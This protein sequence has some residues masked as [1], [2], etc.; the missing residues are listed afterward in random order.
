MNTYIGPLPST[1][2]GLL[3]LGPKSKG[4]AG[5]TIKPTMLVATTFYNSHASLTYVDSVLARNAREFTNE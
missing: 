3:N 1:I 5:F 4:F 2:C